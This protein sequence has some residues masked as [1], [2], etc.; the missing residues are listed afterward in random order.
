[1]HKNRRINNFKKQNFLKEQPQI[2][3]ALVCMNEA[4]Y[5]KPCLDSIRKQTYKNYKVWVC[6]NQPDHW[7]D[8]PAN[9]H[10]CENNRQTISIL[11]RIKDFPI[12]IIDK[13]SPGKGWDKKRFGVGWAR[14]TVMDAASQNAYD[15]DIIVSMDGDTTFGENYFQS[16]IET[17]HACNKLLA[18]SNPYYHTL[19]DNDE[20]NRN[21][22]RYEI[23]MRY[24][25]INLWRIGSPYAFTA[26]GSAISVRNRAYKNSGGMTPKKSGED[27]YFIQ[28]LIK[29]GAVSRYNKEMVYPGNRYSDRVFFGTGPAL[30]KGKMNDWKSYPIYHYKLFDVIGE[31]YSL[32]PLLFKKNIETPI[33]EFFTKTFKEENIWNR[34]RKNFKTQEHF[35]KACHEKI[36]G[37]RILQILKWKQE[38]EIYDN[39]NFKQFIKVFFQAKATAYNLDINRFS[40]EENSIYELNCW[41]DLLLDIEQG[42]NYL[43]FLKLLYQ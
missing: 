39:E 27:F 7:W 11:N 21:M 26:L 20:L 38:P 5:I 32:F 24:Y 28:K 8:A 23:Y 19:E 9:K 35:V 3:I 33:D 10:I 22:L 29:L 4:E 2:H 17:F 40:F 31:V 12:E 1:M 15:K 16:I 30:I 18:I 42:F 34:M 6:V 25:T 43:H 36:D 13:S 14:K 37:L 41:R